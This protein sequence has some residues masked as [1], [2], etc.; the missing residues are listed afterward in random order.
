MNT[1]LWLYLIFFVILLSS[2]LRDNYQHKKDIQV[3]IKSALK[4]TLFRVWIAVAFWII[5]Y[6]FRWWTATTQYFTWYILE[7]SLS[8]D[9]LFVMMAIFTSFYI[10][11]KYRHR[12]LYYWILWAI[13]LRLIFIS[14]WTLLLWL[15]PIVL[16]IFGIIVIITAIKML[17]EIR[18][19]KD[20]NTLHDHSKWWIAKF[21][22]KFFPVA[23]DLDGHKFFTKINWKWHITA[24]FIALIVIELS[25]VLFA[26]DSLPAILSISQDTFIVFSSNI[27]AILWLRALYFVLEAIGKKLKHISYAV[28]WILFF[29]GIKMIIGLLWIHIHSLISLWFIVMLLLIWWIFSAWDIKKKKKLRIKNI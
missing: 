28:I 9:N 17:L 10:P 11:E 2:I 25:D 1:E 22:N 6:F 13:I 14:V 18:K 24:L 4:E 23:K 21:L 8:V 20:E 19:E 5:V 3:T 7:K 27:F 16:T 12:V 15:G 26:F 29:V